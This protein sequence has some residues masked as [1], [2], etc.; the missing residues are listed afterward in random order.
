MA[1]GFAEGQPTAVVM[2]DRE[3]T[4]GHS[5]GAINRALGILGT[6]EL[7]LESSAEIAR[8][9]PVWIWA[10]LPEADRK[11]LSPDQVADLIH[12]KNQ[13]AIVAAFVSIATDS[14]SLPGEDG[15]NPTTAGAETQPAASAA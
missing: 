6:A 13:D 7:K 5:F 9:L 2:L 10:C 14:A 12:R 1:D 3:R 15:A 11:E 8:K 4:I